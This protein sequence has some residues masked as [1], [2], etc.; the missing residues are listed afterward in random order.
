MKAA[1]SMLATAALAAG[2]L[3]TVAACTDTAEEPADE[4]PALAAPMP[5]GMIRGTV[6]E[7]M[8][9]VGY[10]YVLLDT[11]EGQRWVAAQQTPVA[12]GDIVQTNQGMAMQKFTS[13]SLNRTF[14]VIYFSGALQNLSA[15][16]LPPGHP[17]T[18]TA[19]VAAG[20]M[21]AD[22]AVAAVEE[23]R[24]IAWVYANMDS[25]AGQ[26][27]SLRGKVVKYN[28]N[29]LGTNWLHIQDGSGS[30]TE[31]S[32]D[33]LVTSAAEAAVGDTVVVT[34]NI[35]LDKDFSAG[36]SYAVLMEDASLTVE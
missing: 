13:P 17:T 18:T 3:L 11:A 35:A 12:V 9:A 30:A 2:L 10:T 23:G 25:L 16:T 14:E 27:V 20:T 26:P 1:F 22:T 15:T 34:G 8:D 4:N 21:I 28:A 33:L 6:L 5:E 36:Y 31:G 19:P 24:D 7:T 29:I 32:N